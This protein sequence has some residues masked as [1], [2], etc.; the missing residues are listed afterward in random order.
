[1]IDFKE[2]ELSLIC[3]RLSSG[4]NIDSKKINNKGI[5]PVYGG[6]GIR[7]YTDTYNFDGECAII[8]RQGAFCGNI[9]YVS[10][11]AYMTEHA[12]VVCADKN[13]ST[14]YLYYMLKLLNLRR[15]SSQSAQPGLSVKVIGKQIIKIPSLKNQKHIV[16]I[17]AQI[18]KKIEINV[19]INDNLM[20]QARTL[21]AQWLVKNKNNYTYSPLTNV[22]VINPDTY[23]SKEAWEYINYLDTGS[24]TDGLISE[25]QHVNTSTD[26]L[27][28]RAR[29]I[30]SANDIVFSTVRPNQ[31]HFGLIKKPLSNMLVSTGFAVIRSINKDV[32]NELL[33]LCLTENYFIEK[34][35]QLAE[36]S[37]STYPAIKPSDLGFC[38]IPIPVG[39][40]I[41]AILKKIFTI[42]SLN[43][44]ENLLL[45]QI[46]DSLLP[47]LISGE[48]DVSEMNI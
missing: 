15:L 48:L 44:R 8:G 24:I 17:L 35:Q 12:I 19:A 23:S 41:S 40:C 9:H 43:Q 39:Q 14:R 29:R 25:I 18:D 31:R 46:R 34:M 4:K 16:H 3:S 20:R 36:Q 5:Y 26:K 27:P 7:G 42:I 38:S 11:K 2:Y 37:A 28:S 22:A 47:K 30:I 45:S 32:C 33:Y 10:G 13:N 6:N 21:L 1:M